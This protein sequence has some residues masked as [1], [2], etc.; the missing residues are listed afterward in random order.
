MPDRWVILKR[1]AGS[2]GASAVKPRS[3]CTSR[4][5]CSSRGGS[6]RISSSNKRVTS[7]A[8]EAALQVLA[9]RPRAAASDATRRRWA[10]GSSSRRPAAGGSTWRLLGI[11]PSRWLRPSAS[12]SL[13]ERTTWQ[14][15]TPERSCERGH[16]PRAHRRQ[17][18]GAE[19]TAGT[20]HIRY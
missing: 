2:S 1:T 19:P 4:N 15:Y 7:A 3:C 8:A 10:V 6:S 20:A 5:A 14:V 13:S 17:S 18:S 16:T 11:A 12:H 9:A